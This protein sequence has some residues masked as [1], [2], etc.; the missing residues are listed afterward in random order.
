MPEPAALTGRPA[1]LKLV[2]LLELLKREPGRNA[3]NL[4]DRAPHP[5]Y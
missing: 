4:Q 1:G 5:G 3:R 2:A